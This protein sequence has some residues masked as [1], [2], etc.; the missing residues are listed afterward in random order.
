MAISNSSLN[1]N[2]WRDDFPAVV[3]PSQ[4]IFFDNAATTQKPQVVI[5]AMVD[6]W[7]NT[8][9]TAID[10]SNCLL[11]KNNSQL[12]DQAYH[13]LATFFGALPQQF[14]VTKS[15]TEALNLAAWNFSQIIDPDQSIALVNNNHLSNILPWQR[16]H[17]LITFLD[18]N[19]TGT[20]DLN[21]FRAT[22]NNEQIGAVSLSLVSNVFGVS[23][24]LAHLDQLVVTANRRR[25]RRLYLIVDAAAASSNQL[26]NFERSQVDCLIVSGHK[27]YGPA[28]AGLMVKN[29]LLQNHQFQPWLTGGGSLAPQ[30]ERQFRTG[31]PDLVSL[32]GWAT[33]CRWLTQ[34]RQEKNHYLAQLTAFLV[35]QLQTLPEIHLLGGLPKTHLVSFTH[36]RVPVTDLAAYLAL[37]QICTRV[38]EH[39]AP[40]LYQSLGL[41]ESLR[42]SLAIYNT[43]AEVEKVVQLLKNLP[44]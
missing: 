8:G 43:K 14:L 31:V 21:Q 28:I 22:L 40:Q 36:K 3:K 19:S 44:F 11:A 7:Q 2:P 20:L 27:M 17:P 29:S 30:P 15:A 13:D 16:H 25:Q 26:I 42:L 39:C 5:D 9:L 23:E 35:D 4:P 37:N 10:R 6:L 33:A 34:D 32:V 41:S 12:F 38:G 1:S 18:F 24:S